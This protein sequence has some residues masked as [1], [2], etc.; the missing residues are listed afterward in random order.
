MLLFIDID[1][2]AVNYFV[3]WLINLCI[4]FF[5]SINETEVIAF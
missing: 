4:C 2:I 1:L 5:I 3:N